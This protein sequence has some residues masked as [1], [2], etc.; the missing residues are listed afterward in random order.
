MRKGQ[1]IGRRLP[2]AY[3]RLLASKADFAARPPIIVNSLPKSGTHLL[4][5]LISSVPGYTNYGTFIATTPSLTMKRR[6]DASLASSIMRL[7]PGEIC[8]AHL[9]WSEEVQ[10]AIRRRGAI[11][12]FIYRDPRDV[13]WSEMQ[14]LLRMNRWHRAGRFGRRIS[15]SDKRFD[16]FLHGLEGRTA[17]EWPS[18]VGRVEP[19]LGWLDDL[20]TFRCRYEDFLEPANRAAVLFNLADFVLSRASS[21]RATSEE[22]AAD[23]EAAIRPS[24]SHTFRKGG[25]REWSAYLSDAQVSAL[26]IEVQGLSFLFDTPRHS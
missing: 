15:D 7:A 21:G 19:Y 9:Y 5:Q 11:S 22:M 10:A 26:E 2:R 6:K 13:F 24:E 8:G 25:R 14:Y 3:C 1:A 16:F 17:F 18:L 23:F 20:S 12:L 4:M